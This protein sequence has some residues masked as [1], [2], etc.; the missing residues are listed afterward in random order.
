MKTKWM[1]FWMVGFAMIGLAQ[2][3]SATTELPPDLDGA[4]A[5]K[6]LPYLPHLSANAA[7]TGVIHVL[8]CRDARKMADA[9]Y[10]LRIDAPIT[11]EARKPRLIATLG[12][13][14]F[15]GTKTIGRYGVDRKVSGRI[16]APVEFRGRGFVLEVNATTTPAVGGGHY[17]TLVAEAQG[18]RIVADLV[19]Q[20]TR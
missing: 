18:Q 14:W 17:A 5:P 7:P 16:G 19:C 11:T 3:A 1:A 15:G 12:E 9:G 13:L 2:S 6:I 10:T 20:F 8:V 4:S